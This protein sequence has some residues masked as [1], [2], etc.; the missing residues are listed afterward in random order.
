MKSRWD[1][2]CEPPDQPAHTLPLDHGDPHVLFNCLANEEKVVLEKSTFYQSL[3]F[4]YHQ[5]MF[6]IEHAVLEIET[7]GLYSRSQGNV[8][9]IEI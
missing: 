4:C 6:K 2:N 1:S 3:N 9:Y 8:K 5:L 7:F